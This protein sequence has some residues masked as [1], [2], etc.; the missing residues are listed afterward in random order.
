MVTPD[1]TVSINTCTG[2]VHIVTS[3]VQSQMFSG[4]YGCPTTRAGLNHKR[5]IWQLRCCLSEQRMQNAV[6]KDNIAPSW[7]NCCGSEIDRK[8][9]STRAR[10]PS[11]LCPRDVSSFAFRGSSCH[12]VCTKL[13]VKTILLRRKATVPTAHFFDSSLFRQPN[14][15]T[16]Q[17]SDNPLFW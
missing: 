5:K 2:I 3:S 15:P 4:V 8:S 1:G 17:C 14:G 7:P 11:E 10:T 13:A 9:S 12:L 16:V 6:L